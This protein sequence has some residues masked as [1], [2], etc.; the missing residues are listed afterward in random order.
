MR[1]DPGPIPLHPR[2]PRPVRLLVGLALALVVV[3]LMSARGVAGIYT[4]YLWFDSLRFASVWSG[5]LG[6]KIGLAV[7]FIA[8]FF[9]V[10]LGNLLIA[11]RFVAPIH[12]A[13]RDDGLAEILALIRRRPRAIWV[14]VSVF[15]AVPFGVGVAARW[16]EWILFRNSVP[17]GAKDP[18]FGRDVGFYVFQLPFLSFLTNWLF[19]ALVMIGLVTAAAHYLNGGIRL[20]GAR[21]YVEPAAK[22]HL[23]V[24]A[25]LVA[26]VKAANY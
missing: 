23:S 15:L 22:A 19:A 26:L 17:F 10:I 4:D 7:I 14:A 13:G 8:A 21:P 20:V 18:L 5:L 12:P 16:D 24:L 3:T 9:A 1:P 6:V 11:Q 25:G 2:R